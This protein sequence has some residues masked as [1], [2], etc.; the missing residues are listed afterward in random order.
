MIP[1]ISTLVM[2]F[3]EFSVTLRYSSG[4]FCDVIKELLPKFGFDDY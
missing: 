2:A 4:R 1:R 3:K